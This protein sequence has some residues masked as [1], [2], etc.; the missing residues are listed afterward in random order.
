MKI[1]KEVI[2]VA[3]C[4]YHYNTGSAN[5]GIRDVEIQMPIEKMDKALQTKRIIDR[6]YEATQKEQY[7][8]YAYYIGNQML[9]ARMLQGY[10]S[11]EASVYVV[12]T[13]KVI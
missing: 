5:N 13:K 10:I 6:A 3:F 1:I 7:D 12:T 11:S 8:S 2:I 9:E 4:M